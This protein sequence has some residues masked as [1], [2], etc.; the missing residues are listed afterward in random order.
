MYDWWRLRPRLDWLV[1]AVVAIAWRVAIHAGW[2]SGLDLEKSDRIAVYG[3][4]GGI[5]TALIGFFIVPVTLA[6][7]ISTGDNLIEI[8]RSAGPSLRRAVM[9]GAATASAIVVAT[10]IAIALDRDAANEP[11]RAAFVALFIAA[12]LAFTRLFAQIGGLLRVR[13]KAESRSQADDLHG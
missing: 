12:C 10:P 5:G 6:L 4:A 11:A 8:V 7:T 1:G 3:A 2:I 13:E 9:H